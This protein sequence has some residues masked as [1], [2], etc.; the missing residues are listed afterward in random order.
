MPGLREEYEKCECNEGKIESTEIGIFDGEKRKIKKIFWC[1]KCHGEGK[2]KIE[3][4][5]YT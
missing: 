2:I 5:D 3:V 1:P 4:I